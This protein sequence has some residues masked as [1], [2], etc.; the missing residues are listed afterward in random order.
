MHI[1]TLKLHISNASV[2]IVSKYILV[3]FEKSTGPVTTF[4][5]FPYSDDALP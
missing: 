3:A 2:H 5:P 1:S 4:V